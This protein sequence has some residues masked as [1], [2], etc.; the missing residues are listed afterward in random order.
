MALAR[1]R[2]PAHARRMNQPAASVADTTRAGILFMCATAIVFAVQDGFSTFLVQNHSPIFVVMIRYWAFAAFVL[3]MAARRPGGI[4]AAARSKRPLLQTARGLLLALEICVMVTGFQVLGLVEAHAIF[5]IYPLLVAALSGPV[6]GEWVGWRRW[7]AIGAGFVGVLIILRPGLGVFDPAALIALTA[8]LFFALYG[9][10]TR[11]ASRAD[12]ANVSFFYTGVAGA[13]GLTLVGPFFASSMTGAEIALMLVLCVTGVLGH[14]L[15][16]KAYSLAEAATLQPFAY[17][18]LVAASAIG[19][20]V[21]AET[22]D[23][24]TVAGAALIVGA[25]IFAAFRARRKAAR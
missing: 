25:G 24:P 22:M 15:M 7:T 6:L 16:I 21:F 23:A 9:L 20:V 2:F 18:Q 10:L 11:L 3:A 5:A 12:N 13:A 14:Y 8:A 4:R 19:V 17:L 1:R